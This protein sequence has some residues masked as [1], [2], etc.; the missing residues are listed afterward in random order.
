MNKHTPP[1]LAAF[2]AVTRLIGSAAQ[3]LAWRGL[4]DPDLAEWPSDL[5][6]E[7]AAVLTEGRCSLFCPAILNRS[8]LAD[9]WEDRKQAEWERGLPLWKCDCGRTYKVLRGGYL[10]RGD[11]LY[12]AAEGGLLGDH[13]GC[14][15]VDR[16]GRI[17]H[18]GTCPGCGE[19]FAAVM[20]RQFDPQGALF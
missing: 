3:F 9:H 4:I 11:E 5:V 20:A 14:V 1:L 8:A 15:R 10:E 2:I 19:Q 7:L 6:A 16:K 13:I 18:S 12:D 17:K